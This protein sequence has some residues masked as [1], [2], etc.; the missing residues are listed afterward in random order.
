MLKIL[1]QGATLYRNI[2]DED[3]YELAS[4]LREDRVHQGSECGFH[5]GQSIGNHTKM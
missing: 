5:V 3:N 4:V 1:P 2:S